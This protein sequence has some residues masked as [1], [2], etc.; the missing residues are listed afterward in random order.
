[1]S[2]LVLAS[3]S[4]ARARA[5]RDAG[6]PLA[7]IAPAH[8]DEAAIRESLQ[9]ENA[10]PRDIADAL[11]EMKGRR[12]SARFPG[13][14]VLGA[15]QVLVFE[16]EIFDKPRDLAEARKHLTRLRGK[17]HELLSAAVIVQ[18]GA[19]IWRHIG[20][21]RLTMRP[22]SDRFLDEY[23]EAEGDAVL[24]SVGAYRIEGPGAQLFSRVA[25]DYFS[26]LGLPLLEILGFL[27]A[28]KV[29]TE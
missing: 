25:G 20:A 29:V 19:P 5:L 4:E 23:L 12:V 21:A 2:A 27:R 8:I 1:M 16:G 10:V 13:A 18:D 7:D 22:F 3:S 17:S 6:V 11:A 9:A 28:R 24:S 14:F 15:D 26:I